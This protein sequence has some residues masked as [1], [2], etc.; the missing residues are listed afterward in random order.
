MD[1]PSF[2]EVEL[3]EE[4]A[5]RSI[6]VTDV[7]ENISPKDVVIHFQK[8]SNGG[9]EVV[10][11][12][13][14]G[15]E[16]RS[17]VVITFE[18]PSIVESVIETQH[19][20][21]GKEVTVNRYPVET[22]IPEI[23]ASVEARLNIDVFYGSVSSLK[24]VLRSLQRDY[25]IKCYKNSY[26]F[27]I[28]GSYEQIIYCHKYILNEIRNCKGTQQMPPGSAHNSMPI[29]AALPHERGATLTSTGTSDDEKIDYMAFQSVPIILEFIFT[30]PKYKKRI[31]FIESEFNVKIGAVDGGLNVVISPLPGCTPT[32]HDDACEEYIKLYREICDG[33]MMS[34]DILLRSGN[35]SSYSADDA[36]KKVLQM[37]PIVIQK[38]DD[39]DKWLFYGEDTNV[40]SAIAEVCKTLKMDNPLRKLR[41]AN[42]RSVPDKEEI[43]G[44]VN[45]H[46]PLGNYEVEKDLQLKNPDDM[47]SPIHEDVPVDKEQPFVIETKKGFRLT[48]YQGDITKEQVDII[49]NSTDK[50]L[51]FNIGLPAAIVK[52]GGYNIQEEAKSKKRSLKPGE[53]VI[54]KPGKLSC[55]CIMHILTHKYEDT[56]REDGQ[57]CRRLVKEACLK[58]LKIA[59][60]ARKYKSIAFPAVGSGQQEMPLNVCASAMISA[61]EEYMKDNDPNKGAITDIRFVHLDPAAVEAFKVELS[62]RYKDSIVTPSGRRGIMKRSKHSTLTLPTEKSTGSSSDKRTAKKDDEEDVCPIC[63]DGF[64]DPTVLQK[65]KHKF[66]KKCIDLAFQHR[67]ACPTCG[68]AYGVHTGN[69]PQGT[70]H[71]S[72]EPYL[73]LPGYERYGT[74]RIDYHF[75]SGKQGPEHPNPGQYYSGTSRTAYLPDCP[76]GRKVLDLL[77]KA[78]NAR[79]TFTIGRSVTTGASNVVTWNDIHHKTNPYGGAA[80]FGY[81]DPTYLKRVKDEL[82]AKGIN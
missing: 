60:G 70:M 49:V 55:S 54:T 1:D 9:G 81:P 73:R 82:A 5:K 45:S 46:M 36:V 4:K 62:R 17:P 10:N 11:I 61:V 23:F 35:G 30:V 43:T 19:I 6:L 26:G 29:E 76:E 31:Q 44:A 3:D 71:H 68:M 40:R 28:S 58:C 57:E 22:K 41:K 12:D 13:D 32:Q 2:F 50:H 20:I 21:K 38:M 14:H 25:G 56:K 77:K 72:L 39:P 42:V 51:S 80:G 8:G 66:C 65:C 75:P 74:I 34:K 33:H 59:Y 67:K 24:Q 18:D 69:M 27:T 64:H 79:L 78:F 15:S 7:P 48:V 53:F 37:K 52:H 63:L 16:H 47:R